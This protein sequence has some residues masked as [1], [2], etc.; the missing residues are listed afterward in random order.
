MAIVNRDKDASEQRDVISASLGALATGVT[1][2][3]AVLPY[4]CTLQSLRAAA[5]GV[6]NAMQVAIQVNRFI[7]GTGATAINLGISNLVLVNV[8]TSGVQ[9]FSGLAAVGSTLLALQQN[10]VL[11]IVTSVANGNTTDLAIEFVVK[12]T[13]DI[14]TLNGASS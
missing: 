5:L 10:D 7:A 1:K 2:Q 9:G 6:S 8:G 4:P 13:Q 14:I 12:K 3:V 11:Q